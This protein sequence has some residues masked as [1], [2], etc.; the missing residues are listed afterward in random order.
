MQLG[1]KSVLA[2]YRREHLLDRATSAARTVLGWQLTVQFPQEPRPN[3]ADGL[4]SRLS[5]VLTS[6]PKQMLCDRQ[7]VKQGELHCV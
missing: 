4:R 2:I 7:A 3:F 6:V 1:G 5:R